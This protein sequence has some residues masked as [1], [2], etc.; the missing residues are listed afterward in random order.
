MKK[1]KKLL[2]VLQERHCFYN[3]SQYSERN[4]RYKSIKPKRPMT[5][6]KASRVP[7]E[8]SSNK[9]GKG[10]R[11]YSDRRVGADIFGWRAG[12]FLPNFWHPPPP[13]AFQTFGLC[14]IICTMGALLQNYMD[15]MCADYTKVKKKPY[16]TVRISKKGN[17][18]Y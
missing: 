8:M 6:H 7:I 13:E 14:F 11:Q 3:Q 5:K 12:F 2:L 4:L 16:K 9:L 1:I 17:K 10:N 15:H 18:G